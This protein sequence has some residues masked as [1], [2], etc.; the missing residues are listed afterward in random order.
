MDTQLEKPQHL[1]I[2]RGRVGSVLGGKFRLVQLLG[3]GGMAAVYEAQHRNGK[4]VALKVMHRSLDGSARER[5]RFL[6]EAYAANTIGHDGVVQ[7]YDDGVDAS[8]AVFLVMELLEGATLADLQRAAGGKLD[9][10]LAIAA[11]NQLLDVLAVAH[12]RG[13]VHRDI[14]PANLFMTKTGQ[15][16]VLDFGVARVFEATTG[17]TIETQS[18]SMLGTPAF[19]P[20]EQARGRWDEV[21]ARSD[22]WAVGATL[23]TLVTGEHVHR[24]ETPNEQLGRAMTMPARSLGSVASDLPL[25]F[26]EVVDRALRY[27]RDERWPDARAM[28][29]AL[30]EVMRLI[31]SGD[32]ASGTESWVLEMSARQPSTSLGVATL[33]AAANSAGMSRLGRAARGSALWR[34]LGSSLDVRR[35]LRWAAL[36]ALAVIGTAAFFALKVGG[37]DQPAPLRAIRTPRSATT[38]STATAAATDHVPALPPLPALQPEASTARAPAPLPAIAAE[39]APERATRKRAPRRSP[40]ETPAAQAP[41][42]PAIDPLDI[43]Y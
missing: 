30:R 32:A 2:A 3:V 9:L 1:G 23:F 31:D 29:G 16:K 21:E 40:T 22:L 18:G 28:R 24:G 14:K 6:R 37:S 7:I 27:E 4:R 13:V 25:P 19:M 26:V 36:V 38:Y 5:E 35:A 39:A 10:S 8:G 41:A 20:Q 33:S 42:P 12:Q 17:T 34:G 11:A 15:L 43:R